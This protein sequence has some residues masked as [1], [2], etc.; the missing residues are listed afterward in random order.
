LVG[1]DGDVNKSGFYAQLAA[2]LVK[3]KFQLVGRYDSYD[4]DTDKATNILTNYTFGANYIF[5]P[6]VLIQ[7]AYTVRK[8][9]GTSINNNFGSV[10]LQLTF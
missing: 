8:E 2:F 6:N 10:Q 7:L 4:K 1:K 5:N 9:Q 3:D